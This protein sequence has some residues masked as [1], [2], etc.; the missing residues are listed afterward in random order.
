[1]AQGHNIIVPTQGVNFKA[2]HNRD[3]NVTHANTDG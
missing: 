3:R 1:M 2:V